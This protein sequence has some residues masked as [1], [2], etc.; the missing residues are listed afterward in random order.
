MLTTHYTLSVATASSF[1]H[2]R[3]IRPGGRFGVSD[4]VA[5]GRLT[6][7]V[8]GRP[9]PAPPRPVWAACG[10]LRSLRQSRDLWL[11]G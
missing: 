2:A 1:D 6:R 5:E 9:Q 7:G 4:T 3:V 11:G 10:L 8:C